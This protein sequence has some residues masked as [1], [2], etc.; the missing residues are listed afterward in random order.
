MRSYFFDSHFCY[1][2]GN[3]FFATSATTSENLSN[4]QSV[5]YTLGVIRIPVNSSCTIGVVKMLCF[6]IKYPP[7]SPGSIP[8]ILKLAIAHDCLGS[9]D[10]LNPTF[11]MSL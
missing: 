11:G 2:F 10:V 6:D 8:S 5:V 4:S 1:P 3:P 7:S 9:N